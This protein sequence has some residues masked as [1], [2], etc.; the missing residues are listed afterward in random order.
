MAFTFI[1]LTRTQVTWF[2]QQIIEW[3]ENLPGD[4]GQL[5][6]NEQNQIEPQK[7]KNVDSWIA[8]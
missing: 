2:R 5:A 4:Q 6:K 7:M 1:C 8:V 3:L